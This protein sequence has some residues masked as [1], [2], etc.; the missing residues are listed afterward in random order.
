MFRLYYD[1]KKD[2]LNNPEYIIKVKVKNEHVLTVY[3]KKEEDYTAVSSDNPTPFNL[4]A[5]RIDN[6]IKKFDEITGAGDE[7]EAESE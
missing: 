6:I 3:P 1:I 4:Y 7:K 5:W 2:S